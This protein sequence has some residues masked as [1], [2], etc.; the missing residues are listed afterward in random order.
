M[1]ARFGPP[2]CCEED[3]FDFLTLALTL[4]QIDPKASLLLAP[5]L[6]VP[7]AEAEPV[8]GLLSNGLDAAI[9]GAAVDVFVVIPPVLFVWLRATGTEV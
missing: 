3:E 1:L 9:G 8:L 4:D 7:V 6:L 5:D 2:C